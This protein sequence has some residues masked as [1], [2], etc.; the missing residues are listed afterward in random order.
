MTTLTLC[1]IVKNEEEVIERCLNSIEKVCD[2]II[3]ADTGSTDR[4][5]EIV[6]RYSKVKVVH[7]D[8]IN[9]FSAA[10]NYSFSHATK[11]LILWL[12]ADDVIKP[13]DLKILNSI[14]DK[15]INELPDCYI[16]KYQ[17]AHDDLDNVTVS[18]SRERIFKRSA[19]PVWMYRIHEC[20]PLSGFKK[21]EN[22]DFEVHH[23]KT[24]KQIVRAEG[25][26]LKILKE[27]CENP[28]TRCS[29]Y[30]FYY[31]KELADH[32][33]WDEAIKWLKSYLDHWDYYEDAYFATYKLAE[34]EFNKKDY[35]KSAHYCFDALKL[36]Q[37]RADLFCFLGLIY[38]NK[39]RWDLA[40]FW[41]STAL[42]MPYPTDSLGFFNM[43]YHTFTPHFQLSYVYSMLKDWKK[44]LEHIEEA[45]KFRPTDK[46][47]LFNKEVIQNNICPPTK[48]PKK[49]AIYIP[50]VYDENN[51]NI[52][53]R[54]V[55]VQKAL[56]KNG[57]DSE[58]VTKFE[59]LDYFDYVFS[60]SP[61]SSQELRKLKSNGKIIAIDMAE[62]IFDENFLKSLKEYNLVFCSSSKL[63]NVAKNYNLNSVHLSDSFEGN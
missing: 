1:M 23:Y 14:K 11:D 9:D 20:V 47:A 59:K 26:N 10:R 40:K 16:A 61:F 27:C 42:I 12:D 24:Q 57:F 2:E 22:I 32:G 39:Q 41:Y 35:D 8:W 31:G 29:R 18:L 52:R 33:K 50:F 46:N 15:S 56:K 6:S 55:N 5:L 3:I 28:Q 51:P 53:L 48:K 37:R 58:I 38:I 17:Y 36:D 60:H 7:F 25:R 45:L 30:E 62:G 44:A 13:K 34:I 63:Q 43:T 49:V 21:I 19:N 4:T 54:K